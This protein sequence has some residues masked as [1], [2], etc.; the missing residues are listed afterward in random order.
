MRV[1]RAAMAGLMLFAFG[2]A[3]QAAHIYWVDGGDEISAF[4]SPVGAG[5]T[6][7]GWTQVGAAGVNAVTDTVAN[8]GKVLDGDQSVKIFGASARR[9]IV[10]AVPD[11]HDT[12]EFHF[13][14]YDD[15]SGHPS[16]PGTL[17]KNFRVG[18]T[19]PADNVTTAPAAANPRFGAIAVEMGGTANHSATHYAWHHSFAF[20]PM[21]GVAGTAGPGS[22]A[23]PRSLGWHE[24][25][26][27]WDILQDVAGPITRVRFYVDGV[28]GATKFHTAALTPTG[29]WVGAPFG[30]Q[31]PVW[32][33]IIPEPSALVLLG[34]ASVGL[35]GA[36]RRSS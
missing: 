3:A 24:G 25:A 20:G 11:F 14:F 8:G 13:M 28:L 10:R 4:E 9:G 17:A 27:V 16:M 21:N 1:L 36:R 19:R 33:D 26:L 6:P 23:R 30:S 15:M 29:E 5:N 35:L 18:L 32:V 7:T 22:I 2:T 31:S 34:I 12:G